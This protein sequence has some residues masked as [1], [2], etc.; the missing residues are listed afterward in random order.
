MNAVENSPKTADADGPAGG[1]LSTPGS[2]G[3]QVPP[4]IYPA[5]RLSAPVPLMSPQVAPPSDR[6]RSTN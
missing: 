6:D 4:P 2:V 5:D 1:L 3:P